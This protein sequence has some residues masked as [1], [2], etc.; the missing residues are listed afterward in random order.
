MQTATA[1][2][3]QHSVP[4]HTHYSLSVPY[5]AAFNNN[6]PFLFFSQRVPISKP[7]EINSVGYNKQDCKPWLWK[8][9][10]SEFN[11]IRPCENILCLVLW[12]FALQ[13]KSSA[14]PTNYNSKCYFTRAGLK[15]QFI[16][17]P[18]TRTDFKS[19]D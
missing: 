13:E 9:P 12:V 10:H 5:V 18:C 19:Q 7:F 4:T 14:L 8:Y 2:K 17:T 16:R 3:G 6:C 1:F 15:C 11:R